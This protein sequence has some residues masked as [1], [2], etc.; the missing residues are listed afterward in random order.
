[1]APREEATAPRWSRGHI[2]G[3]LWLACLF[4]TLLVGTW[5]RTPDLL[6]DFGREVYVPW[7]IHEGAVLYDDLHYFNGPLSPHVNAR[8]FDLLG[9]SLTSLLLAN[10]ALLACLTVLVYRWVSEAAD[11]RAATLA[12]TALLCM[13]GFGHLVSVGNYNYLSPYSHEMTHGLLL[14]FLMLWLLASGRGNPSWARVAAAGMCLGMVFLTK[15]E[16]FVA[17]ATAALVA[18]ALPSLERRIKAMRAIRNGA[19]M[20]GAGTLPAVV[21]AASLAQSMPWE[22]ALQATTGAWQYVLSSGVADLAFYRAIAGTD[23]PVVSLLKTGTASLALAAMLAGVFLFAAG[24][25]EGGA[26]RNWL[27]AAAGC[28]AI[29]LLL[30]G[31][32]MFPYLLD[33]SA[34]LIAGIAMTLAL[35]VRELIAARRESQKSPSLLPWAVFGTAL[36]G[37]ML[38]NP[39][40][41]HYGFALAMPATVLLVVC[42]VHYVPRLAANGPEVAA[43]MGTVLTVLLAIDI[44]GYTLMSAHHIADKNYGVGRGGDALLTFD[45]ETSLAGPAVTELLD[46]LDEHVPPTATLAVLPEGITLNY[47]TRRANPTGHTNLMPPELAIYGEE[48]ILADFRASPPDYVVLVDKDTT[49]YGVGLFGAPGYGRKIM[50]WVAVNYVPVKQI[51]NEPLSGDGFGIKLLRRAGAEM[52]T[53]SSM[54]KLLGTGRPE[55]TAARE[56]RTT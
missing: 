10:A 18:L 37:K 47:L 23:R 9:V 26:S 56:R 54:G 38:L 34:L 55:R 42:L 50:R 49:E 28:A 46:Y 6:I 35:L 27:L 24:K 19:L 45:A 11:R 52:E 31:G 8:W 3:P 16:I 32:R 29:A 39:R 48:K 44:F 41:E 1:M 21:F 51:L 7:Q 40:I 2:A 25:R 15:P 12:C 14:S 20:L 33:G 4:A 43:R 30:R 53:D 36:L 13:F 22:R 5:R 17:A